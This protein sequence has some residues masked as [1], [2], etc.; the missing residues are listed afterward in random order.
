MSRTS[1]RAKT[2]EHTERITVAGRIRKF[3]VVTGAPV[4]GST[5]GSETTPAAHAH[6]SAVLLFLHGSH[7]NGHSLRRFSGASFDDLASDG[8]VAVVYPHAVRWLWNHGN[9]DERHADDVAFMAALA[10]H[11][12]ALYG[13]VPVIAAG[14]SNG[15]QMVIR[16]IHEIPEKFD[17]AAIVSATLPRPGGL[18]FVDKHMPMPVVL[19][20]GT[21][22]LVVPYRGESGFWGLGSKN[23]GPSAPQTAE[24]FAARNKIFGGPVISDIPSRPESGRTKVILS[25]HDQDGCPP[26][27]LYT[28][29]GGGHVVPNPATRAVTLLGRTTRDINTADIVAEFFPAL[30]P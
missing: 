12:R 24:Y 25:S 16:M 3:L 27:A 20:H 17:G 26:V 8:R 29:A 10:D 5:E 13:P 19:I 22:D 18:E 28:V 14:Y 9:D 7:Q 23:R 4:Q 1:P 30:R 2:Y 15:G 21:H 6:P 11:F